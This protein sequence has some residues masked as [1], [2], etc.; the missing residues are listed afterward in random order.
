MTDTSKKTPGIVYYRCPKCEKEGLHL[1]CANCHRTNQFRLLAKAAKCECEHEVKSHDCACGAKVARK[2]FFRDVDREKRDLEAGLP[3]R[4]PPQVQDPEAGRSLVATGYGWFKTAASIKGQ[5]FFACWLVGP[6][7][8]VSV[9]GLFKLSTL[10]LVQIFLMTA[11]MV[12]GV[13]L[14]VRLLLSDWEHEWGRIL[15]ACLILLG[16]AWL[17]IVVG[18]LG[19]VK[20]SE[21]FPTGPSGHLGSILMGGVLVLFKYHEKFGGGIFFTFLGVGTAIAFLWKYGLPMGRFRA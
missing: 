11:P 6:L 14:S 9:G 7:V 19:G 8:P 5:I 17:G 16:T 21:F 3:E 2:F 15:T 12:V 13:A 1:A 4:K 10:P 18:A 20:M